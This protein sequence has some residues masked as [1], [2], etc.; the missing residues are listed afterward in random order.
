MGEDETSNQPSIHKQDLH[1]ILK[2]NQESR[3][4]T[5]I[6][7]PH[8]ALGQAVVQTLHDEICGSSPATAL[9]RASR[10]V[11]FCEGSASQ[12]FRTLQ[13]ECFKCRRIRMIH[14]RDLINPL[15]HLSDTTM[16][17]GLSLQFDVAGPWLV[18]TKSKQASMETRQ[19]RKERRTTTKMWCLLCVDYFTNKL[20]VSPL[21][22][23]STG[24]LFAAIQD[25]ITVNQ[26]ATRKVFIDPGSS[27]ITAVQDTSK[28]VADLQDEGEANQ[29]ETVDIQKAKE[30]IS[31]L[32]NEGFEVKIPFSKA[33][34]HQ[35]KIESIIGSFK[36]AFAVA[37][38]SGSSPLSIVTFIIV[39]RRC[40]ALLNSRPD[41]ANTSTRGIHPALGRIIGFLDPETKSQAIVQY[42][43]Q[44]N[45]KSTVNRPISKLVH[46]VKAD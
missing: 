28:A 5:P 40:A 1:H 38:L 44:T 13:E 25:I 29:E 35:A 46:I 17:P 16:V 30:L 26:W 18:K 15:L 39:I 41:L 45:P 4:I 33:S 20:E 24:A 23:M 2:D 11:Y 31:V 21:E 6:I 36:T 10:Y 42:S 3:F 12:L 8:T 9:A 22:D 19:E 27:L 7:H 14:G 34:F 32:R 43:T 37:Q